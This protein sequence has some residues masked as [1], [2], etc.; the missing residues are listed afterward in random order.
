MRAVAGVVA[1]AACWNAAAQTPPEVAR[2]PAGMVLLL[3]EGA[4]MQGGVM[5]EAWLNR[6][7]SL[8]R[9]YY[10]VH[11]P[12]APVRLNP[13]SGINLFRD[14]TGGYL[15]LLEAS[16]TAKEPVSAIEA[17]CHVFDPFGKLVRTLSGLR[18]TDVM[19]E[20][21]YTIEWRALGVRDASEAYASACYVSRARTQAGKVYAI[22]RAAL[23]PLVQ[24]VGSGVSDAEFE[25]RPPAVAR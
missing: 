17:L 24:R 20:A 7:S 14:R 15:F 16:V 21:N 10:T 1:V 8:I 25:V 22:D 6:G 9:Q 4:P 13:A 2:S 19:F 18:V 3:A 23:L 12:A 11:D 5:N